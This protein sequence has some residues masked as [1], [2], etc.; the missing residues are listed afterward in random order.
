[1]PKRVFVTVGSTKFSELVNAMLSRET[2]DILHELGYTDLC[3]QYGADGK[4]FLEQSQRPSKLFI[5]GF[6]YMPSIEDQMKRAD[7]II[8]H[9]GAL[10]LL[11]SLI[12]RIRICTG[13]VAY[14]ET[15]HRRP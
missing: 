6:D 9:A 15:A 5:T 1:M 10:R 14:A 12:C 2:I 7:L 8:S 3:M 13:G 11:V 4:L